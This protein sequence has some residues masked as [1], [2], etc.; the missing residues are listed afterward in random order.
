MFEPTEED[1]AISP[2]PCLATRT[3]VMR[4]GTEVPAAK[5]VR[6]MTCWIEQILGRVMKSGAMIGKEITAVDAANAHA[7]MTKR[8]LNT[9]DPTM[10]PIPTSLLAMNTPM[11][12]VKSSGA[13]PP[14]AMKVAPA[15]SGLI[16]S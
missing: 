13:D 12:E 6:P 5:K 10:V 2:L 15:T 14:A 3:L 1:T 11:M 16:P 9:A 4:S 7:A 8:I